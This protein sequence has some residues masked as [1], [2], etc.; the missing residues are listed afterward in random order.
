MGLQAVLVQRRPGGGP[1][2]PAEPLPPQVRVTQPL[3]PVSLPGEEVENTSSA[4][5]SEFSE[6]RQ[7]IRLVRPGHIQ[8]TGLVEYFWRPCFL[9]SDL[10]LPEAPGRCGFSVP[11]KKK[12]NNGGKCCTDLLSFS[13]ITKQIPAPGSWG[14]HSEAAGSRH[15][16]CPIS[17]F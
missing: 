9:S 12:A 15:W 2:A 16:G 11:D 14:Y 3:P 13:I 8:F 17:L 10:A 6:Q 1:E 5:G 7:I 4:C